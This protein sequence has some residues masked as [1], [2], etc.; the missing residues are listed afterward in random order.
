MSIRRLALLPLALAA[1]LIG[2]PSLSGAEKPFVIEPD[3]PAVAAADQFLKFVDT[4]EY[5]K[6]RNLMAKRVRAGGAASDDEM[7]NYLKARRAPLGRR[8]SRMLYRANYS[9]TLSSA[10]D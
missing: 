8:V 7:I 2:A 10:P 6:A 3:E 4:G 5:R 1:I 9:T